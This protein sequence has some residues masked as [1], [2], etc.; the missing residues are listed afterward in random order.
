MILLAVPGDCDSN[1]RWNGESAELPGRFLDNLQQVIKL[2]ED[3]ADA[4]A[5]ISALQ[6]LIP[7]YQPFDW[8]RVGGFEACEIHEDAFV[9]Q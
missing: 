3:Q 8:S 5:I 2:A 6:A 4:E 9:G 7:T 1:V